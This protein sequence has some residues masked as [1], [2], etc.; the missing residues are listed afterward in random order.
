LRLGTRNGTVTIGNFDGVTYTGPANQ[1]TGPGVTA[2]QYNGT[3]SG[4]GRTGTLTGSFFN[5]DADA[6]KG[7]G[8]LFNITGAN[9]KAGGIFAGQRDD[10]L[11]T[12]AKI[13]DTGAQ[14]AARALTHPAG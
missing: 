5:A 11:P 8:G 13:L 6:A 1:L 10:V 9:Y 12:R 7:T 4:G 2:S 3:L 14:R